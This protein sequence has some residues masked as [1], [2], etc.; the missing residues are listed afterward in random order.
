MMRMNAIT[1]PRIAPVLDV[2]VVKC[3]PPQEKDETKNKIAL[4]DCDE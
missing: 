2:E 3:F 4:L 1:K